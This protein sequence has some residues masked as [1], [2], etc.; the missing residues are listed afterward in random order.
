MKE[1]SKAEADCTCALNIDPY[2]VKSIIRRAS[3]RNSLGK[4]RAALVDLTAA[5]ELDNASYIRVEMNKTKE[6][7]RSA[8]GRAPYIEVPCGWTEEC[9]DAVSGPVM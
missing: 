7:L 6:I 9:S 4:H 5:A 3:A 8:V 2:Y 1:Y